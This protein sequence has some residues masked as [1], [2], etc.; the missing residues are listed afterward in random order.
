MVGA[1]QTFVI[2]QLYGLSA[3]VVTGTLSHTRGISFVM[4]KASANAQLNGVVLVDTAGTNQP[5]PLT[6][7]GETGEQQER[8]QLR[9]VRTC[10]GRGCNARRPCQR[11]CCRADF[12]RVRSRGG[13][14]ARVG[15]HHY[16]QPTH[17]R[18]PG[19][20]HVHVWCVGAALW[21]L[22][23]CV[24][25]STKSRGMLR[26]MRAQMYIKDM[27]ERT[28]FREAA[29]GDEPAPG[30]VAAL[31]QH[32]IIVHNFRDSSTE[33][34]VEALIENDIV[35]SFPQVRQ[36]EGAEKSRRWNHVAYT[37]SN[38]QVGQVTHYVLAREGTPA[39]DKY[40]AKTVEALQGFLRNQVQAGREA[41]SRNGRRVT[42]LDS[43][44]SEVKN[45]LPFYTR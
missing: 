19:A 3:G 25:P 12:G 24:L 17:S 11:L 9:K 8:M 27:V 14:Q 29:F 26:W 10:R 15:A 42:L 7:A 37:H 41:K 38:G 44:M 6:D 32:V 16:R 2:N 18:R 36:P 39:G 5:A 43:V 30:D 31:H 13:P 28:L 21:A 35:S 23:C 4:P 1:R 20:G 33:Q 22:S 34:E 40:N 45:I